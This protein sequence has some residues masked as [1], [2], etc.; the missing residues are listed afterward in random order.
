MTLF[1]DEQRELKK[2][3]LELTVDRI[4]EKYGEKSIVRSVTLEP[5]KT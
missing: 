3:S 5:L 1:R 2:E 4:R